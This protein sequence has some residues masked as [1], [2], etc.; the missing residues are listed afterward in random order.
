MSDQLYSVEM[1]EKT[2]RYHI[3]LSSKNGNKCKLKGSSICRQME[4]D[5]TAVNIGLCVDEN[6]VKE[7]ID[8]YGNK[9]CRDCVRQ[10]NQVD[11]P[12]QDAV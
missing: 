11:I 2:G 7:I 9:M 4:Y 6:R 8:R 12:V 3:F 10:F 1:N 5:V